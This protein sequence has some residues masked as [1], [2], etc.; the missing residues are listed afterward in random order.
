MKTEMPDVL[1]CEAMSCIFNE[2]NLCSAGAINVAGPHPVCD[3]YLNSETKINTKNSSKVVACMVEDCQFNQ[4][5]ECLAHGV[6]LA[7][8]NK[9]ALCRTYRNN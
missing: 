7:F 4:C 2:D 6:D 8:E 1:C 5:L 9:L 3:I